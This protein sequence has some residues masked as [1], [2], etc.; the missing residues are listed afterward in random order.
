MGFCLGGKE[1]DSNARKE[2]EEA[3]DRH[4]TSKGSACGQLRLGELLNIIVLKVDDIVL[5]IS[6]GLNGPSVF[7]DVGFREFGLEE[8]DV[9]LLDWVDGGHNVPVH[10]LCAGRSGD[11]SSVDP[12]IIGVDQGEKIGVE[13]PVNN[14]IVL[15]HLEVIKEVV[16]DFLLGPGQFGVGVIN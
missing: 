8:V 1:A 15:I 16:D 4:Q 6:I 5:L 9:L 7:L 11:G 3:E 10:V 2:E 12:S 14:W 13:D